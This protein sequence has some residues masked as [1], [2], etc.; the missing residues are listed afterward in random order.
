MSWIWK[1]RIFCDTPFKLGMEKQF[2][3]IHDP[4]GNGAL[5][6][7]Y[8]NSHIDAKVHLSGENLT[9]CLWPASPWL[10]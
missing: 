2:N 8:T 4:M 1:R 6:S 9:L 5:L 3:N 10:A 7:G